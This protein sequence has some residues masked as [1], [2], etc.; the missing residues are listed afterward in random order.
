[1]NLESGYPEL[2]QWIQHHVVAQAEV[3]TTRAALT[4]LDR[5]V[6]QLRASLDAEREALEDPERAQALAAEFEEARQRAEEL[7]GRAARWQ[8][9]LSDGVADLSADVDHLLRGRMRTIT[10]EAEET[11]D[12]QDPGTIWD[13]FEAWLRRRVTHDVAA[14]YLELSTRTTELSSRVADH[15]GE[16]GAAI[17]VVLD[18]EA[19]LGRAAGIDSRGTIDPTKLGLAGGTMTA[20]RGS[21]SGFLMFGMLGQLAGLTLLNPA[22]A[23]VGLLM[24][25]KAFRDEKQRQ[26]TVKRQQAMAA[27][28]QFVD[29][30]TFQVGKELRDSLRHVQREL[31]D[32]YTLRADELSRSLT[33][34]LTAAKSALRSGE[35][36]RAE[37]LRNVRAELAR[38]D[39]LTERIGSIEKAVGSAS[40]SEGGQ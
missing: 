31:R 29:E 32:A 15:F 6:G 18:A 16:G 30:A 35:E 36:E 26:L 8:I 24:G 34:A 28:R 21:Y 9:T 39:A 10:R 25:R 5:T 17:E 2:V 19:P 27:V 22:T 38:I 13:E 3:L 33:D 12:S 20:M 37:R 4:D 7:K 14:T 23:V 11:I 40:A 1:M